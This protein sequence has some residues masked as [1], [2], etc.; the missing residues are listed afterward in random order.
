MR[1]YGGRYVGL[2]ADFSPGLLASVTV[3]KVWSLPLLA[4][5]HVRICLRIEGA[6]SKYSRAS[7]H[8]AD[9]TSRKAVDGKVVCGTQINH[10]RGAIGR[11]SAV[12]GLHKARP[13]SLPFPP[14]FSQ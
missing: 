4:D 6:K 3:I 14:K 7:P 11:L 12:S 10:A 1:L 5:Y 13:Y 8:W 9:Y 2:T